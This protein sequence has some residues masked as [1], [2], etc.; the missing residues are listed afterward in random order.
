MLPTFIRL[1]FFY[2]TGRGSFDDLERDKPV[3]RETDSRAVRRTEYSRSMSS[4]NWR[5]ARER[6]HA[7]EEEG[8]GWRTAHRSGDREK[9]G[10]GTL[11]AALLYKNAL[12]P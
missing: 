1:S 12:L 5:A 11:G 6:E 9:W 3:D 10:G 7:E 4:D 2:L 8:G